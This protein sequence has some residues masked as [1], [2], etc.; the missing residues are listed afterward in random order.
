[1]MHCRNVEFDYMNM[2]LSHAVSGYSQ[3]ELSGK[4]YQVKIITG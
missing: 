2:Y 3:P 1:M 4:L